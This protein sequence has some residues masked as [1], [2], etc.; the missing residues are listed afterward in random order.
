MTGFLAFNETA[1]EAEL[2]RLGVKKE[3]RRKTVG[4]Q[5]VKR[6]I[7]YVKSRAIKK[8]FL[9]VRQ[10]NRPALALYKSLNFVEIGLRKNYYTRPNTDAIVL[11]FT[12]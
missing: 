5:L 6:M 3:F 10:D 8:I 2:L 1:D 11:R 9:E 7:D 4:Q 12:P